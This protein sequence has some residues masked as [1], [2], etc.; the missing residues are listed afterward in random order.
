[1]RRADLVPAVRA[2][3]VRYP[4]PHDSHY[5]VVP[6]PPPETGPGLGAVIDRLAAAT[7]AI[8]RVQ[9]YAQELADPYMVTRILSR[10]EAVSSS[11]IEGTH[12]TLDELLAV[13]ETDEPPRKQARQVRDYALVL[14]DV[15]PE[16]RRLGPR[17]F[18]RALIEHLHA[19]VVR[20]DPDYPDPPGAIRTRV[21]WIGGRDIA[22]SSWNPPPP[23]RVVACLDDTIDYL[24]NEGLQSVSQNLVVRMAI[25]H[26]HFE[27]VHPFR[28]GNGRVGRLLLPMMM[29]ADG[30]VPLYLSSFV[31]ARKEDYYAALKNAQQR[32]DW[33]AMVGFLAD[34]VVA[35]AAEVFATR[36]ALAELGRRWAERRRFRRAAASTRALA[37]LPSYPVVTVK[38]LAGLLAVGYGQAATA[39][40]QLCAAD[41]LVERTGYARNRVFVAHEALTVLNRPF[42]EPPILP[43]DV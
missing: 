13:E 20:S 34:A 23:D 14:D 19:A 36:D 29:A 33:A 43:G 11:A 4:P 17:V 12:S 22:Y 18:D 30:L 39:I 38:R 28:D 41:I 21:V 37:L 25:A 6:A 1:M 2:R 42:G 27:A 7:A 26:A 9:V 8:A 24:R 5:G 15:L 31:E 16:A 10:Q 40:E 35:S 32:L 3:L